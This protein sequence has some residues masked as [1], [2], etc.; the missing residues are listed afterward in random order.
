MARDNEVGRLH[1]KNLS[2]VASRTARPKRPANPG[3]IAAKTGNREDL[4]W[5]NRERG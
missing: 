2:A 4:L 3:R 5:L 1:S